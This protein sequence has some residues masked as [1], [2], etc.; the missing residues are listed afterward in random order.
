MYILLQ[1]LKSQEASKLRITNLK[2][3]VSYTSYISYISGA[4]PRHGSVDMCGTGGGEHGYKQMRRNQGC[5]II[6]YK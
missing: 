6:I 1:K 5:N 2:Y 3:I 4:K